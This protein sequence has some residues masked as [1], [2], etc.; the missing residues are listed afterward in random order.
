MG[1]G[2]FPCHAVR[3]HHG[4]MPSDPA[5]T[6]LPRVIVIDAD[7]RVRESLT[8]LLGIGDRLD[9]VGS[10]SQVDSAFDLIVATTPDIVVIDPRLPELDGG[11]DFIRRVR[12]AV[13]GVCVLAMSSTDKLDQTELASCCDGFVRKTF[14][15]SDLQT[16][17]LVASGSVTA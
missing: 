9:V 12:A 17:V 11:V 14:R 5:R 10:A 4:C 2:P 7:D 15:P 3:R 16:A 13:P 8:G 6:A 1:E